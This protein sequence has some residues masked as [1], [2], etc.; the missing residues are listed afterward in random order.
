MAPKFVP[1]TVTCVPTVAEVGL[2]LEMPGLTVNVGAL[3]ATPPA[4]T[5]T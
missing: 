2:R 5:T 4:V 1:V 3:L